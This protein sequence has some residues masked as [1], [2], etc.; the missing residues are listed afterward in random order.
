MAIMSLFRSLDRKQRESTSFPYGR[1]PRS[2]N[3]TLVPSSA[4]TAEG[5]DIAR[6]AVEIAWKGRTSAVLLVSDSERSPAVSEGYPDNNPK[7]AQGAKK[8]DL[9]LVPPVALLEL[10]GVMSLGA[11][12]YGPYNWREKTVSSRVYTAAAMRH[13]LQWQDGEDIDPESG[14]SHLAH[15]MACLAIIIDATHIERLND[16]RPLPGAASKF[17]RGKIEQ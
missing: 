9:S 1:P 11:A 17:V 15:A 6:S 13:I 14:E 7:T 5:G 8:P 12:K 10:A 2:G 16:N 4:L 3:I